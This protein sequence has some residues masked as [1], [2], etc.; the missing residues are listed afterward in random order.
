MAA[1]TITDYNLVTE[2]IDGYAP[3]VLT[4]NLSLM[5]SGV[6]SS[7]HDGVNLMPSQGNTWTVRGYQQYTTAW[8]TPVA[9]TDMTVNALGTY[10]DI[11]VILRR[12]T[13]FGVE[14]VSRYAGGDPENAIAEDIAKQIGHHAALQIETTIFTYLLP[15]IFLTSGTLRSSHTIVSNGALGVGDIEDGLAVPGENRNGFTKLF[16]HSTVYSRFV[17]NELVNYSDVARREYME[18]GLVYGGSIAG[19]DII[20]NDRCYKSGNTYHSYLMR[21]GG[22]FL[23]YQKDLNVEYDRQVLKAG[24]TDVWK[25]LVYFSPHLPGVSFTGTAPTGVGGATDANLS[26]V[27][28]WTKRTG[29]DNSQIGVVA[30]ETVEA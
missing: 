10:Q 17:K 7:A 18:Q 15:G 6:L 3:S 23:G 1:T 26:T 5:K 13:A 30:I 22:L 9:A 20:L 29:I 4:A 16:M 21:A 19:V 11:G 8:A 25:Y 2:L 14:D 24:G 12:G 28:N 27:G